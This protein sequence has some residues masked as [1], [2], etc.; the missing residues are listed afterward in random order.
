MDAQLSA[1]QCTPQRGEVGREKEAR[2]NGCGERGAPT[3]ES[4]HGADGRRFDWLWD[5]A[6]PTEETPQG[7]EEDETQCSE[8]GAAGGGGE[9]TREPQM[10]KG[11]RRE[12]GER[13]GEGEGRGEERRMWVRRGGGGEH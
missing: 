10:P 12:G 7:D 8:R 4:E 5:C 1:H 6:Y 3:A 2:R 11:E 13:A 9:G